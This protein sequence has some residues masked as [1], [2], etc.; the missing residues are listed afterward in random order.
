MDLFALRL[1]KTFCEELGT[2]WQA[3]DAIESAAQLT[4]SRLPKRVEFGR[5]RRWIGAL[6]VWEQLS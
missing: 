6:H 5:R 2:H 4:L 3:R 1:V